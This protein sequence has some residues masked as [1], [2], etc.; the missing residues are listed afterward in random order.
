MSTLFT[1]DGNVDGTNVST[2]A[3]WAL[4]SG[5]AS[6]IVANADG[7]V[8]TL[9]TGHVRTATGTAN[10]TV[11]FKIA[12]AIAT[13]NQFLTF[14]IGDTNNWLG[15]RYNTPDGGIALYKCVA[16]TQTKIGSASIT[17][18]AAG[19]FWD[20]VLN[21]SAVE[22]FVKGVSKIAVTETA[23]QSSQYVGI[24][25]T[26]TLNNYIDSIEIFTAA[27]TD[28]NG[29]GT[30]KT[31][32]NVGSTSTVTCSGMGN[33]TS[34]TATGT[35]GFVSNAIPSMPSGVGTISWS[36]PWAD[37]SIQAQ[38]GDVSMVFSDG[39]TTATITETLTLP[40]S[41]SPV[42]LSGATNL[43]PYHL[44]S[45]LTLDDDKK[46]YYA[47]ANG[48]VILPNGAISSS[49]VPLDI[50]MLLHSVQGGGDGSITRI[51]VSL[52]S[53]GVVVSTNGI[54]RKIVKKIIDP[55]TRSIIH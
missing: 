23:N 44:G 43:S 41:H 32:V 33:I 13:N 2:L 35:S 34:V 25:G 49:K 46:I 48:V 26:T 28:V 7:F 54:A 53:S 18:P 27:V 52:T 29:A 42:T 19:D 39:A 6:S 4:L 15:I 5:S 12:S 37:G 1:F 30:T 22:V 45:V 14:R 10:F 47:N 24:R 21:G 17:A 3:L 8:D 50:D 36:W 51:V 20:V 9:G 16:G 31:P 40:S 55:I 11:R 38:F